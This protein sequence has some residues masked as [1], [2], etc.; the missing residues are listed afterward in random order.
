MIGQF[1]RI[2][3]S[4][5]LNGGAPMTITPARAGI[6]N[7]DASWQSPAKASIFMFDDSTP[8][9]DP[10]SREAFWVQLAVPVL[11]DKLLD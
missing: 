1:E 9:G 6:F 4:L 7:D 3:Q 10:C 8:H 5:A 2:G 11:V